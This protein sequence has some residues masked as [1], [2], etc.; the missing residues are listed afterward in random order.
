VIKDNTF[1]GSS[2]NIDSI[3]HNHPTIHDNP[4]IAEIS[5]LIS[6]ARGQDAADSPEH[7]T[8]TLGHLETLEQSAQAG[9]RNGWSKSM[10]WLMKNAPNMI[11]IY[12]QLNALSPILPGGR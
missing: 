9:D 12:E 6:Q 7:R 5:N 3:V 1:N 4:S 2:I 10:D 8:A 11:K